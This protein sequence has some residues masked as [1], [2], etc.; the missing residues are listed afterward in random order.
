MDGG[1]TAEALDA[2]DVPEGTAA[3]GDL[4]A[5]A[6]AAVAVASSDG[7]L[8]EAGAARRLELLARRLGPGTGTGSCRRRRGCSAIRTPA[9]NLKLVQKRSVDIIL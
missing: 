5:A 3:D 6:A 1:C 9:G 7:V 8:T 2:A 4:A